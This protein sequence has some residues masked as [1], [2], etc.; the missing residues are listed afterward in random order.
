LSSSGK[1]VIV[2][3]GPCGLACARELEALGNDNFLVVESG[4]A[5]GGLAA[6]FL[7]AQ[8]FTWDR[9]GHVVF[10][11]FGEFDRLLAEV[12]EGELL[13]HDRSSFV[14]TA[15]RFIPYPFQNNLHRLTARAA[16][17]CIAGLIR[18]QLTRRSRPAVNFEEWMSVTFGRGIVDRFMRPYNEK[19]WAMHPSAL[20]SAWM[21]ERVAV[22][23]WKRALRALLRRQD[24]RGWGPNTRFAFPRAGGTGEIFRRL[25]ATLGDQR[26]RY[27]ET[28]T[29]ID[30]ESR[31]ITM[32]SS[33]VL[34]FGCLVWTGPLDQLVL[35]AVRAPAA[36]RR[37]LPHLRHTSVTVVGIG[38]EAPLRDDR[39]W[40]YFPDPQ[41]PFY[42]LTNFAKY[43][44][45]N[46]P[47]G[48]TE[49]YSSYMAEISRST[50]APKPDP[51]VLASEVDRWI[52]QL[53]LVPVG[54]PI[55]STHVDDI[56]YAY[57]I[58][59]VGR[60][61]ALAVIEPWLER[62][63]VLARGRFGSWRYERGNMDHAVKMGL[64]AARQIAAGTP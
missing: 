10:S 49:R 30:L 4:D 2:G 35:R 52:R 38:Y 53:G 48:Q 22:V 56:P 43:S 39:S 18:A 47:G 6:S 23:D 50:S 54:A 21:A 27:R 58:P 36:V 41:I 5:A 16:F 14:Y 42:R 13:W 9:G 51:A 45:A 3:A 8:G 33:E 57:P 25:A 46:V 26:V 31:T 1:I 40:L 34:E 28:V 55:A 17:D 15:G 63:G 11:H 12:L 32:A 59:T 20:S 24:D 19:V 64:D 29:G 60:D 37:M 62:H 7:D 61:R 44:P